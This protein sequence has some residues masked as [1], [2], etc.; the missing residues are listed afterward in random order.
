MS[1]LLPTIILPSDALPTQKRKRR[2]NR[3]HRTGEETMKPCSRCV[4]NNLVCRVHISSGKCAHCHL[5]NTSRCDAKVTE[6]EWKKLTDQRKKLLVELDR[7]KEALATA[8]AKEMRLRKQL[9]AVD[10]RVEE[11]RA[12]EERE[13][14]EEEEEERR[15]EAQ[16]LLLDP[17][18][19][20]DLALSPLT[21]SAMGGYLDNEFWGFSDGVVADPIDGVPLVSG[22]AGNVSGAGGSS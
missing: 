19:N 21:F 18:P 3:I 12:L 5:S 1:S 16:G 13:I 11:G 22:S 9:D 7:A 6:V 2:A 10:R 8:H 14:A 4:K 20:S 15:L 17:V